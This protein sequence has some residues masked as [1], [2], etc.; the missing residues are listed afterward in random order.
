MKISFRNANSIA[1]KLL[2]D[3]FALIP[4]YRALMYSTFL[5]NPWLII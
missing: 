5:K 1:M 4:F 2:N 3:E